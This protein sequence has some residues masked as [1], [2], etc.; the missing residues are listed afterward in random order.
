MFYVHTI[1]SNIVFFQPA[2]RHGHHTFCKLRAQR[3]DVVETRTDD[4]R[5]ASS[6]PAEH[7]YLFVSVLFLLILS[8][9]QKRTREKSYLQ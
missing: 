9:R 6:L 7:E 2:P 5:L 4:T 8:T 3:A 1:C